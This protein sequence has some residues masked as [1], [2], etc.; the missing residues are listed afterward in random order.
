MQAVTTRT[1]LVL[2]Q[3]EDI[4]TIPG[5]KRLTY[6]EENLGALEIKLT[7][8]DLKRI[9]EIAPRGAAAG[10]RHPAATMGV[11]NG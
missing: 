1:R 10:D 7:D 2:A 8:D 11:I 3:G 4:V 5:T 6:L 9:D